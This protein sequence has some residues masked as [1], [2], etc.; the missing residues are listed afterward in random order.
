MQQANS[1]LGF[2]QIITTLAFAAI[3]SFSE[4]AGPIINSREF[5][6]LRPVALKAALQTMN[7]AETQELARQLGVVTS[8]SMATLLLIPLHKSIWAHNKDVDR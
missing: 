8:Q 6:S 3:S 5:G 1:W 2:L 7:R 4:L